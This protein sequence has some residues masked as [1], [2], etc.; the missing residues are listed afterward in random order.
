MV[1]ADIT[2]RL[3]PHHRVIVYYLPL[4][5]EA[6][7]PGVPYTLDFIASDLKAV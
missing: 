5:A 7:A 3:T 2:L 6:Q 4:P 1:V